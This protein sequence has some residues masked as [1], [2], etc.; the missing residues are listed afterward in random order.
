MPPFFVL[1]RGDSA[2]SWTRI[3]GPYDTAAECRVSVDTVLASHPGARVIVVDVV[4]SF[5]A[6]V[7]VSQDPTP[8]VSP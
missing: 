8:T 5:R 6:A 4:R 2:Q 3:A 1:V 7:T